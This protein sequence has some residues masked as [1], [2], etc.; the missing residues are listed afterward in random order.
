MRNYRII[1]SVT[2]LLMISLL[3]GACAP[4]TSPEG[5]TAIPTEAAAEAETEAI[6]AVTLAT[7][8]PPT[9]T[10]SETEAAD[11]DE[12]MSK[13]APPI[14]LKDQF[15]VEHE[16]TDYIGKV[17]F[18]NFWATWC[19]PCQIEMPD[20]QAAYEKYGEN[21]EDV[22]ILGVASPFSEEN[23]LT[24][25]GTA[26]E[27]IA[28]LN[29]YDY[30]YPS[31]LDESGKSFAEYGIHSIPMTYMISRDGSVFGLKRGLVTPE[32]IDRMIEMTM[33]DGA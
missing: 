23:S 19:G 3:L 29:E 12:E 1:L 16:L 10:A 24:F 17:V 9:E 4:Q 11:E 8:P 13:L 6:P 27:V 32:D 2:L 31:L 20:I 33:E 15:G 30:T 7:E 22:V 5:E 28:Y 18:L 26:D 21:K 14:K 25:E